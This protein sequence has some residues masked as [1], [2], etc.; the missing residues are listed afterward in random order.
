MK[1]NLT[2]FQ[3]IMSMGLAFVLTISLV[4]VFVLGAEGE[5][6]SLYNRVV[7][8]N[9][10]DNWEKYFDMDVYGTANAGG[11]WTDKSVFT[12]A[13]AFNGKITMKDGEKNFLTALSAI[14]ANKEVVGYSTVP[15]DTVIILDLS[16]S[17]SSAAVTNLVKATNDAIRKLNEVNNNNRVGVVLYSGASSSR[18]YSNAVARLMPIGRYDAETYITYAGGSVDVS[19]EVKRKNPDVTF[20]SKAHG[21]ATYIQAGL[22]EAWEMFKDIPD[23]DIKIGDNN[24]Q[25]GEHR[26]PIVV[27]MSD[28]A[29]TLGTT[30]YDNVPA[31][32][33]GNGN[34][35]AT[36]S[37]VGDGKDS[38][39]TVGQ[40]FLVQLT[41]SYIKTRIENKYQVKNENGAGRS[42]FYTLG[43]NIDGIQT[44]NARN[45]ALSV[46]DPESST[47]TDALWATY[48]NLASGSMSVRVK[49]LDGRTSDVAISK[50]SYATSKFYVDEYFPASGDGLTAAFDD[51][52]QEILIQSRY[53]PTH[54]EGGSP[55]FSGYVVFTDTL[56]DYMEVKNIHGILLGDTLFDGH[57]MASKL[58][59][60]S[61]DG[62]GSVDNPTPL[63]DEF[64]RAL[65][66]RLGI[67]DTSEVQRLV[68]KAFDDGQLRYASASDWS[69]FIMWYA[70]ADGSYAGFYDKDGTEPVP[71][72]AVYL[73]CSYGFLGE[74][75]GSIKNSDMMY[76]SV[77]VRKD[78]A[79]GKQTMIWKIPA[80]LVPMI[81]YKVS[82]KGTNVDA[83]T[84][85]NATVEM[86]SPVRLIY[87]TGLRSD[88]N[89]YNITRISGEN[90]AT[91]TK[92]NDERH[93]AA[94]GY[95]RLFWNNFFDITGTNHDTHKVAL[96]KFTP[97]KENERF[98]YT[99]D[100]AVF[101]KVG[102]GAYELVPQGQLASDGEYYHRRYKFIQYPQGT[103]GADKK[104][105][106]EY[107]KMSAASIAAAVWEEDFELLNHQVS[108][109]YVVPKGT[110][111]RELQMF[112]EEKEQNLTSSAGMVFHP[113]IT[114]QN[115]LVYVDMNLGNNGLLQVI[116]ATGFKISKT[117][118]I[119]EPGTSDTFK[120]RVT[121]SESGSFDSWI[122]ALDETPQGETVTATFTNGV[123]EFEMKKDQTFWLSGVKPGTRYTVEEISDNDDYKIK[124]VHVNGVSFG[125]I[126]SGTVAQYLM[127]DVDFVNTAIGEGDLVITK[128]V[129]DEN[130]NRVDVNDSVKFTAQVT[131]TDA[132]GNPVSGTFDSTAGR[133][134]VDAQGRFTVSLSDGQSF[135]L[136]GIPEETRYTVSETQIPGGFALNSEKSV[137]SGVVDSSANDQALIV[138]TY[139]P[140]GTTGAGA[141]VTVTKTLS[142]N[143]EIWLNG[144]SYTFVL[145]RLGDVSEEVERIT[146]SASDSV[147]S[148]N[149]SLAGESY[150]MAGTYYYRITEQI[151]T[152][153]GITYDTALREFEVTVADA[154][155]DGDL[156]ITAVKN[157][158]NTVVTG[159]WLVSANFNNVYALSGFASAT[160]FIQKQINENRLLAGFQF[161]LYDKDP[162]NNSDANE[163]VRSSLTDSAGKAQI[164][165]IYGPDS[166][167]AQRTVYTYSLAEIK[168]SNPNITYANKVYRVE[169]EVAD[170]GDGTL[171]A[172]ARVYDGQEEKANRE[173]NREVVFVNTYTPSASDFLAFSGKKIISTNNRVLN[174]GEFTFKL[175]ARDG[176]PSLPSESLMVKNGADGSFQFDAIEFTQVG[177]YKYVITED[178]SDPI[179]GFEYDSSRYEITVQV[180]DRGTAQL[181]AS[182]ASI[183]RVKGN[184]DAQTTTDMVFDNKY[185][186]DPV[187][188]TLE[189]TKILTGKDLAKDEFEFKLEAV[190][191]GAPMPGVATVKNGTADS[192]SKIQFGTITYEKAGEYLYTLTEVEKTTGQNGTYRCDD[193]VYT[194]KVTV[195]DNS[196]GRLIASVELAKNGLPST[197]IVFRNSFVPTPVSYDIYGA[198]GGEKI[199]DGRALK[200]GEFE[201]KLINA[202]NGQ[203]IGETVKNGPDGSFR[204]P[205]VV[206]TVIGIYHYKLVEVVGDEK[207]ID[208]DL[209][210]YHVRLEVIQ[211]PTGALKIQDAQLYKGIVERVETGGVPVETITYENIT[212]DGTIVF[213]NSYKTDPAKVIL[214]GKKELTGRELLEGEFTFLL[215]DSSG[216]IVDTAVNAADGSFA[217]ALIPLY[218]KAGTY[219][220]TVVED[221][222]A[223]EE[224][225]T[226]DTTVYTVTVIITDD[227]E[228][229]LL[230]KVTYSAGEG[231]KDG[232]VFCNIYNAVPKNPQ[233]SDRTT[234][235]LWMALAVSAGMGCFLVFRKKIRG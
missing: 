145:E 175:E 120:F 115:N 224:G 215:K 135:V 2:V 6:G 100:S 30:Y 7:D 180:E 13:D 170:N 235:L 139:V 53:Y 8:A 81:T 203:Q 102:E 129:E 48:N 152:Q 57:M 63:G 196:E 85:V 158:L 179:G 223:Q 37:N 205:A 54:L 133:T 231:S 217:F 193:A 208:Y 64:I 119:F 58:A 52:V 226:Y 27:L 109:A 213:R 212:Q 225:I 176:A 56:G 174:P 143:R 201:F 60:N 44:Q 83:A 11:V 9:T 190:A 73:N 209:S 142:G 16:N 87:E 192:V 214:R 234:V 17:M 22:W 121:M 76:M 228:G 178:A 184:D 154:D 199:L 167:S 104:P 150:R 46:L 197:E 71:A 113:Y 61:S 117:V 96:A 43:F 148:K 140:V 107:E 177:T 12:N 86:A 75:S 222:S 124:T 31:S 186:V 218:D 229:S 93:I 147:K 202:V 36:K 88:L 45:I 78:I 21:G 72:D 68:V 169:V 28:G 172:L 80:A 82:L 95:T 127:D 111:A 110:P 123:Y 141:S 182:I 20:N 50:N 181:F 39:I 91:A 106:F 227:G 173:E 219:E 99:F 118:D 3:R 65:K 29:P 114:E 10:M 195:R 23:D 59:D 79:T 103:A 216:S 188:V 161:A 191:A 74:T 41:A 26:M 206:L 32:T 33:Y 230:D 42:L 101:R 187:D 105:V 67:S 122:T 144:E 198:F 194:V 18:T 131:L 126:A 136:R 149:I 69:N 185:K 62:L 130:G 38:N 25:T 183:T 112:D 89:E 204:F 134:S 94:D 55:D 51:I 70:K 211:D 146:I 5:E 132:D 233:T 19:T 232:I 108:G 40:G 200:D 125:K 137:L 155:L 90:I 84:D 171:S 159:E 163:I 160:V 157:V 4:P 207:C 156:E 221:S 220:Y 162:V 77:Q 98:Y 66:T 128:Q 138:N 15:T 168:G 97:N 35:N 24:W 14:S 49:N 153:G 165:L 210:S 47:A 92:V 116:P 166:V 1:R 189:G 151:G 34:Q 164:P